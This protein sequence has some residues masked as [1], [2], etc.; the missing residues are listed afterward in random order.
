MRC[1]PLILA[2]FC[3]S[4][5]LAPQAKA[6]SSLFDFE[7]GSAPGWQTLDPDMPVS[8]WEQADTKELHGRYHLTTLYHQHG[9]TDEPTGIWISPPFVVNAAPMLLRVGGG[10][11]PETYVAL[12]CANGTE[13]LTARGAFSTTMRVVE[14]DLTP[15]I[16]ERLFL[17]IVDRHSGSWGHITLDDVR[18]DAAVLPQ[19]A[20]TTEAFRIQQASNIRRTELETKLAA[21]PWAALENAVGFLTRSYPAAYATDWSERVQALHQRADA[22]ARSVAM[23][24]PA[25]TPSVAELE[26]VSDEL[27]RLQ[28][29]ALLA[30][31]LLHAAPIL[32]VRRP[33]YL[34]DHHNTATMFVSGEINT[35][36][37]RGGGALMRLDP[38]ADFAPSILFDPG[39]DAMIRDPEVSWDGTLILFA[40]RRGIQDDYHIYEISAQGGSPRQLTHAAGFADIDPFYLPDGRI[41]FTSTRE[42]K[43][44]MCNRH[45]MGNLYVMDADGANIHQ[46]GKSTLHEGH[47]SMLP[48][49]RILYD[50]W[51]YVD[52]NFGDAQGLWAVRPDGTAHAVIYGNNSPS[53]GVIDARAVPGTQW[54]CAILTSCHDRPWGSVALLDI[55]RGVDNAEPVLRTWPP[56][57]IDLIRPDAN[58]YWDAFLGT[59]PK[60][61]DPFPLSPEFFLVS[62]LVGPQDKTA[63]ALIDT[64]GNETIVY[65][66]P[67]L[68]CF[69]PMPLAQRT[70]PLELPMNRDF[71]N[72]KG[73]FYVYD[74]Y[75]GSVM[76]AVPRGTVK[77]LRVVESPEK[78]F[79]TNP[80]WD[81][82]GVHCPA[83]NWHGFENKRVLGTVPV[84]ADGSAY[85]EAPA[86]TFLY[87]QL[88]D[89]RKMMIQSM[90]S[91]TIVQ[92][93][94]TQ[95][96]VGCH[97]ERLGET[98][99]TGHLPSAM[100]RPPNPLLA[101][102]SSTEILNYLADIQPIFDRNCVECHDF[103]K[104]AGEKL[105]LAGD[106]TLAFNASYIDLWSG[107]YLSSVGGGPAQILPAYSWGAHQSR[108]IQTLISG[109]AHEPLSLSPEELEQLITWID[110]NAP[111]YPTYASAWSDNPLGR[112][113]ITGAE[114]QR[115][116]QLTQAPFVLGHGPNKRAQISFDRPELSPCL[117]RIPQDQPAARQEALAIIRRGGERLK[118]RPRADMPGFI[119]GP[120]DQQR[121]ERYDLMRTV[122]WLNRSAIREGTKRFDQV[123]P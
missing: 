4:L 15:W 110:L 82:Q 52:R 18:V 48:D 79:W 92:S 28:R 64:F 37:Y 111:Y 16:G 106:K 89:E 99:P 98:A 56:S 51:E 120:I 113:P 73:S 7:S 85:F 102:N 115:L 121:Q 77:Y 42:P 88:L 118:E 36:S 75:Q 13:L 55:A 49:G 59:S 63:L 84:E 50:R 123:R 60:Y 103:G 26:S 40:M 119:P 57:S 69:D 3:L 96:C 90:R 47:G 44:C 116:V 68:G 78:R 1:N 35:S 43:Y 22:F 21:Y 70:R 105:L 104:P 80:S 11:H 86:D 117:G 72:Q 67:E 53:G 33:Q 122:E 66:E 9:K 61:E 108:L 19:S 112:A 25:N 2:L 31:P 114:F 6:Q 27:A 10:G 100:R 32:F 58:D 38:R 20:E 71:E 17:K 101:P 107:G 12:C 74:V 97:D 14:W 45:I 94:E 29:D 93:G 34:P 30:N 109:H 83:M 8:V 81:G 46:I 24:A 65:E 62:R 5:S 95:G 41:G 23:P 39:P 54:I 91:G 76:G 87:F